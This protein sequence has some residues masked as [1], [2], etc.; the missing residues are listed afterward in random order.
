VQCTPDESDDESTHADTTREQAFADNDT[1]N[2]PDDNN[3]VPALLPRLR[4]NRTPNYE[5][6][7]SRDGD[8]SLLT[9]AR[10]E[11]FRGGRHQSHVIL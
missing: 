11:E 7:K 6:L 9:V 3:G 4:R 8:G 10:P 5:H 2:D 1:R